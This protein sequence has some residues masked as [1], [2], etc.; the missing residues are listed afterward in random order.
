[1]TKTINDYELIIF[2][3]DGVIN[4][5][6]PDCVHNLGEFHC[7][8]GSIQAIAEISKL[9]KHTA[10]ATN[11]SCIGRG[12]VEPKTLAGIHTLLLDSVAEFG[13]SLDT[14]FVCPH[15]P[16][17]GCDCRKPAP[18]LLQNALNEFRVQ[19]SNALY[20]GDS[21]KDFLAASALNMD[22]CLVRTGKGESTEKQIIQQFGQNLPCRIVNQ[23]SDWREL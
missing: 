18:K 7:I 11:Q 23:L 14:V 15:A 17:A 1:M 21:F 10:L 5:D 22:F 19:A 20:F 12:W 8:E 13:G 2:D 3:R 6:R 9:G 16:D 4:V